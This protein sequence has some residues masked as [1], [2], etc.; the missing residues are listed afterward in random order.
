MFKHQS[1]QPNKNL[2]FRLLLHG[3]PQHHVIRHW[4]RS[5]EISYT[6]SGT[7]DDY[8]IDGKHYTT[9]P[10]DILIINSYS[11]HGADVDY[12]PDRISLSLLFPKEFIKPLIR[13]I[14]SYRF[15]NPSEYCDTPKREQS[16]QE[17]KI[18]FQQLAE[19]ALQEV[20]DINNLEI[21][22][23]TYHILHI[24]L[25]YFTV[26][27]TD[28]PAFIEHKQFSYLNAITAYIEENYKEELSLPLIA[29]Y[30]H[31]SEGHL[32]RLFKKYMGITILQYISSVRL[33]H[34]YQQLINSDDNLE[35]IA[36][37]AGFPNKKALIQQFRNVYHVTPHQYRLTRRKES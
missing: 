10:G 19:Y 29:S 6:V 23:R 27:A 33:Q 9:K 25:K 15:V 13:E 7:I 24:L 30:V 22:S 8:Y 37:E 16:Y 12:Q 36:Y 34:A 31:L 11:I 18:C 3:S 4:H 5:I 1:I 20:S 32:I 21:L 28:T 26:K 17:L 14:G 35:T 2:P